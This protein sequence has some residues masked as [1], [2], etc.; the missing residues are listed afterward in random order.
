MASTQPNALLAQLRHEREERL[1]AVSQDATPARPAG[2]ESPQ[3]QSPS[4]VPVAKRLKPNELGVSTTSAIDLDS[5]SDVDSPAP[6]LQR[7]QDDATL[8]RR[9]QQEEYGS[10]SGNA[11]AAMAAL[12]QEEEF[13]AQRSAG[14][15]GGSSSFGPSFENA[16]GAL[17]PKEQTWYELQH[18][19]G[20]GN[21]DICSNGSSFFVAIARNGDQVYQDHTAHGLEPR[22]MP[23]QRFTLKFAPHVGLSAEERAFFPRAMLAEMACGIRKGKTLISAGGERKHRPGKDGGE[24]VVVARTPSHTPFALPPFAGQIELVRLGGETAFLLRN[25]DGAR[26]ARIASC[27]E[28]AFGLNIL[29]PPNGTGTGAKCAAA[30]GNNCARPLQPL[31]MTGLG[32]RDA[33]HAPNTVCCLV[34]WCAVRLSARRPRHVHEALPHAHVPRAPAGAAQATSLRA[35]RHG[36]P[37]RPA[38]HAPC[39]HPTRRPRRALCRGGP[40]AEIP[41]GQVQPHACARRQAGDALGRSHVPWRLVHVFARP[42]P[43]LQALLDGRRNGQRWQGQVEGVAQCR[44]PD[45]PPTNLRVGRLPALLR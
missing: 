1:V 4:S 40:G 26:G 36:Q 11:D 25:F 14:P 10:S 16:K 44:L 43:T 28:G 6:S 18:T 2:D 33:L 34:L 17:W 9:L 38:W 23:G 31:H 37:A 8:A 15:A 24:K 32:S 27:L 29:D 42:R 5:D 41:L 39:R 13:A 7:E 12:L 22:P 35:H 19:K 3:L 45:V 20:C 21:F 30:Q